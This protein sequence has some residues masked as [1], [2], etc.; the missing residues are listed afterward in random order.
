MTSG[1]EQCHSVG[2]P[3]ADGTIGNCTACHTRHTSSV[4]IARL[5]STCAQCHMGPGPFADRDLRGIQ[6]RSDV[7]GARAA[8]ESR[9]AAE[10]FDHARHV[11]SHLRHLSYERHQWQWA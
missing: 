11:C 9:R 2:R 5:P 3:N 1:C 7:P 4:R 6:A 10:S 8:A